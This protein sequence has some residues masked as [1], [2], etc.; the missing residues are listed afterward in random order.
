[1]RTVPSHFPD[2]A[3]AAV[4]V[5]LVGGFLFESG[6]CFRIFDDRGASEWLPGLRMSAWVPARAGGDRIALHISHGGE[7]LT[8]I[9]H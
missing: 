5:A 3:H 6:D 1:M 2:Q 4:C 8:L 9:H 7:Q